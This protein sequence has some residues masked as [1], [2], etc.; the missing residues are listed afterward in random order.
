VIDM[1]RDKQIKVHERVIMPEE[2]EGFEQC[3]LT[4]TAAEVTPV[5]EIGDY[6]FEVGSLTLDVADSYEKLVRE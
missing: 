6:N 2:L 3:W 1:L 5:G 4:G